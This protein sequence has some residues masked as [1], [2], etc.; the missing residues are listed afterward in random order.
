MASNPYE[1]LHVGQQF[2]DLKDDAWHKVTNAI[3]EKGHSYKVQTSNKSVWA[4]V[5]SAKEKH[6]CNFAIRVTSNEAGA[7]LVTLRPHTCP[8]SVHKDWKVLNS[9]KFIGGHQE[10]FITSDSKIK[11]KAIQNTERLQ[12][13]N[14]IS[15]KAAWRTQKH[16]RAKVEGTI[17]QQFEII[18]PWLKDLR[19]LDKISC[20]DDLY[21]LVGEE[22]LVDFDGAHCE[23]VVEDLGDGT[24]ELRGVFIAPHA[25]I[26]AW[27]YARPLI[28]LDGGHFL[29]QPGGILLMI[30][31]LDPDEEIF[32]LAWA[33]VPS[34]S[35]ATWR[36]FMEI[37]F[38]AFKSTGNL[39]IISDRQKGLLPAI[40]DATPEDLDVWHYFCTE[41][42]RQNVERQFGKEI[43]K[44]FMQAALVKTITE[45]NT[46]LDLIQSKNP[47]AADYIRKI[48]ADRYAYCAAPLEQFPRFF[49]TTSNIA[50]SSNFIFKPARQMSWLMALDY[51]WHQWL[52]RMTERRD[53]IHRTPNYTRFYHEYY[54]KVR[55]LAGTYLVQVQS[56][57][58]GTALVKKGESSHGGRVVNIVKQTCTCLEWQDRRFPCQHAL[59]AMRYFVTD[60]L[61][62]GY[63]F[64]NETYKKMYAGSLR[65]HPWDVFEPDGMSKPPAINVKKKG[66]PKEK[67]L[68][69]KTL[70][71]EARKAS[72]RVTDQQQRQEAIARHGSTSMGGITAQTTAGSS[73]RA[74]RGKQRAQQSSDVEPGKIRLVGLDNEA[75]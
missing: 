1:T 71:S 44:L 13:A 58:S 15:Y 21:Q 3:A 64:T 28:C 38:Q 42:L 39:S 52:E 43:A 50:E 47:G 68:R 56:R 22:K 17:E 61:G 66:R 2:K 11:P 55:S 6:D 23:R 24:Q 72:R 20:Y 7:K 59:A 46:T 75:N 41:H 54:D 53:R 12:W 67:R 35:R 51:I 14:P 4:L 49:H 57:T 69:R 32:L 16:I 48:P 10:T 25:S 36:W 37:F 45:F 62:E 5:C 70:H 9:R 26:Q 31:T 60:D 19:A 8:S 29:S 18:L 73:S 33:I 27:K 63:P 34:E 40:D 65:P 30:H 74:G